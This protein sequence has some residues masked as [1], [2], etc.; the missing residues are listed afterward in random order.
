VLINHVVGIAG[1][2]V[3]SHIGVATVFLPAFDLQNAAAEVY[4]TM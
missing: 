4:A 1:Q 3:Q 2:T